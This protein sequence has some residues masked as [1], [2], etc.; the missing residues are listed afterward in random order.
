MAKKL[1]LSIGL[2][3]VLLALLEV[4]ARV[5]LEHSATQDQFLK[6]ASFAQLEQRKFDS[7]DARFKYEPHRYLGYAPTPNY[8]GPDGENRHN[9]LGF[10]GAE[11]P[12]RKPD[13]EIRIACLGGSTTYTTSVE[14]HSL[15]YPAQLES[16]LRAMGHDRVRVINGG[17]GGWSSW[18]SL[19][20]FQLRVLELEPDVVI[21]YHGVNDVHPRFVWPPARY[22]GDNSGRRAPNSGGAF[23][24]PLIEH[25]TLY[26][27]AAVNAGAMTSHVDISRTLDR[28]PSSFYQSAFRRQVLD[29]TYPKG[30]F[31]KVPAEKMLEANPP[32]H[33]R[34]NLEGIV[35]V[36]G[37]HG[38]VPVVATF[39]F[40]PGFPREVEVSTEL[41]QNAYVEMNQVIRDLC[42][43]TGALL[44][45]FAKDFPRE[46]ALYVDGRHVNLAGARKKAALFAKFLSANV[47]VGDLAPR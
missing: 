17:G 37:G 36:A 42:D 30:I 13:G 15:S 21:V 12:I 31:A 41:Y 20:N 9:A 40:H 46:K 27:I 8:V 34:R 4:G 43:D 45:D 16:L 26:R 32:T 44:Y 7:G 5:W 19:L 2:L 29:G 6:Y 10:R 14:D 1:A 47:L 11:I 24:P 38:V 28:F 35:H 33:F 39:A 18:E 3:L 22:R 23:M 25:S